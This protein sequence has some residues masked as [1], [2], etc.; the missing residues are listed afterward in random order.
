MYNM[1][2]TTSGFK[3]VPNQFLWLLLTFFGLAENGRAF[4][5]S[6]KK[7]PHRKSIDV[8]RQIKR[9]ENCRGNSRLCSEPPSSYT[10]AA[11]EGDFSCV[12]F[13][14]NF[15]QR[16]VQD[17]QQIPPK[18]ND[19]L[20]DEASDSNVD[21]GFVFEWHDSIPLENIAAL[22]PPS[23]NCLMVGCGNSLL[24]Q[25][26]L[27]REENI[28][29]TLLDTSQTC[30]EQLQLQYGDCP[31]VSYACGSALEMAHHFVGDTVK[32]DTA[33]V[34]FFCDTQP[35]YFDVI[36]DKGLVDALMCGDGWEGPVESL[37]RESSRIVDPQSGG[38][39]LLVSYKIAP[40]IQE[41]FQELSDSA[42]S[43]VAADGGPQLEWNWDFDM[44]EI[45]NDRV[46]ISIATIRPK[47]IEE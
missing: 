36:L 34:A 35:T 14:E 22:I 11:V 3:K 41:A 27:D 37:L 46:S 30:L 10:P 18:V 45:S 21:N 23:S 16:M 2:A 43:I 42:T 20:T 32:D 12:Y 19:D 47:A 26:V 7:Y 9:S 17:Q 39:Y 8:D 1:T 4:R 5:P 6:I 31:E 15:Y 24:P 28:S 13:W 40:A 38:T 33:N 29:I 44:K 25:V